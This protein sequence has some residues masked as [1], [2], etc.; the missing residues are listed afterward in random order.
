MPAGRG[1]QLKI[2]QRHPDVLLVR[3][4]GDPVL[5]LE[6][7]VLVEELLHLVAECR[8]VG[9]LSR[10]KQ[11]QQPALVVGLQRLPESI[12]HPG[13]IRVAEL[14]SLVF[15]VVSLGRR[16]ASVCGLR[17]RTQACSQDD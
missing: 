8:I 13:R 6:R 4:L 9:H 7:L 1:F 17:R 12:E 15:R 14:R 5:H 3:N 2:H 11:L 10:I 16:M